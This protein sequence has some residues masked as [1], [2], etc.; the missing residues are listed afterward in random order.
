M[1]GSTFAANGAT[2]PS[3]ATGDADYMAGV[4]VGGPS[5]QNTGGN[6][7]VVIVW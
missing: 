6:G 5:P 1:S 3:Q 4:G 7:L 2:P